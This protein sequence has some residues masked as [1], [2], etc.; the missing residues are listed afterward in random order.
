[1]YL[2]CLSQ[3]LEH[4]VLNKCLIFSYCYFCC[5][6]Y[7]IF[8]F[9]TERLWAL[10]HATSFLCFHFIFVKW[11]VEWSWGPKNQSFMFL[12]WICFSCFVYTLN[13]K[14]SVIFGS[15]PLTKGLHIFKQYIKQM[16]TAYKCF[17]LQNY[18]FFYF[19]IIIAFSYISLHLSYWNSNSNI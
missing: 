15:Y 2:K 1:M 11:R 19:P 8:C 3:P 9:D 4:I 5:C 10:G 12:Q 18:I 16:Q 6:C 7:P 17:N 13:T 14:I